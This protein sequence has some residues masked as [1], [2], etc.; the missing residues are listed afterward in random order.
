[1]IVDI[2]VFIAGIQLMI[3]LLAAVYGFTDLWYC[4]GLHWPG[5][6]TRLIVMLG[7]NIGAVLLIPTEHQGALV[8]GQLVFLTFHIC[9]FWLARMGIEFAL[10]KRR[11]G[12]KTGAD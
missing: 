2:L 1:M 6:V 9:I 8:R 5:L 7:L 11:Q 12:Y 3:M 4:I 10:Y